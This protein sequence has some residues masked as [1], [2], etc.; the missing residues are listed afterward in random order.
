MREEREGNA[1]DSCRICEQQTDT[2]NILPP[3]IRLENAREVWMACDNCAQQLGYFCPRHEK[4]HMGFEDGTTACKICIDDEVEQHAE[5]IA[6]AFFEGVDDSLHRNQ[7]LL[8]VREWAMVASDLAGGDTPNLHRTVARA[9]VTLSKRTGKSV[10]EVIEETSQ[11]FG[12]PA[13][14]WGRQGTQPITT[15]NNFGSFHAEIL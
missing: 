6:S 5:E 10:E 12:P 9:I 8:E 1:G 4:P 15:Y 13:S 11:K 14:G 3:G 2:F 7:I